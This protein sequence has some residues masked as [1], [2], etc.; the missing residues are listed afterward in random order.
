MVHA[1]I[2]WAAL[3]CKQMMLH[4]VQALSAAAYLVV[5]EDGHCEVG[6]LALR[7]LILAVKVCK[8]PERGQAKHSDVSPSQQAS[9]IFPK[10]GF[11]LQ[12]G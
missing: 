7:H 12:K 1:C 6:Q 5:V 3:N 9:E 11:Y 8:H 2:R 10:P 4:R